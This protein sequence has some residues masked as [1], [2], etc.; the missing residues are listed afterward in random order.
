MAVGVEVDRGF[1]MQTPTEAD[2]TAEPPTRRTPLL[3]EPFPTLSVETTQGPKTIPDDYAGQWFVL[4]S[5][6][7]D[8]TPVCT[9]EFVAFER[10]R[11]AFEELDVALM[12]LSV[13]RVHSHIKWVEWIEAEF[14][15][16]VSFPI[17]ADEAARVADRLGM[18]H[19]EMGTS[20]VRSVFVVDPGG[21]LRLTLY[22]PMEVGRNVDEILRAIRALQTA[23]E[24]TVATPAN[25][26]DNEDHDDR[27]LLRP[28]SDEAGAEARRSEAE[29]EGYDCRDW[30]FCTRDR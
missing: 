6:P 21:T 22:Y 30:W 4:F 28:P 8:F 11:E 16:D 20:T 18:I 1:Q 19:P 7:G 9:T 15:V 12:G 27:L 23:D 5:H 26:P 2:R 3:G 13:D 10:R 24:E 29:E 17:I 25:W 14:D